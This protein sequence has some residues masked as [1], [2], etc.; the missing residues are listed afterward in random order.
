MA[1][2]TAELSGKKLVELKQN[3]SQM[4]SKIISRN[5]NTCSQGIGE[6]CEEPDHLIPDHVMLRLHSNMQE[7][8]GVLYVNGASDF[9]CLGMQI[10]H[11][12]EETKKN[13]KLVM[14]A[15][16]A[17][18]HAIDGELT[19]ICSSRKGNQGESLGRKGEQW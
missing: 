4:V 9:V 12:K 16:D 15:M 10:R 11:T 3:V 5:K 13:A 18:Q 19:M 17:S 8:W 6:N 2:R 7:S 14:P 1:L